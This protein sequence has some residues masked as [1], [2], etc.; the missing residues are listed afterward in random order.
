MTTEER[1]DEL[2]KTVGMQRIAI[3]ALEKAV[4]T[5]V[6]AAAPQSRDATF[7]EITVKKLFVYNA[8]GE[9]QA[10][11]GADKNGGLLAIFN[12]A[13]EEQVILAVDEDGG[14]LAI[15]NAAG[16]QQAVLAV[17]EEGCGLA[18]NNVAEEVQVILRADEE[19]GNLAIYD[20]TGELVRRIP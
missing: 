19:G 2:E 13:G 3:A 20:K 5:A 12:A 18:I 14:G 10:M 1:F 7:D 15:N 8:A 11:L 4:N 6:L 17:D 16:E 9:Q